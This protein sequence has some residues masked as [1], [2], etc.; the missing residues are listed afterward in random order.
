MAF[1]FTDTDSVI[2]VSRPGDWEP[3][4]GTMLGEW[5]S[6]LKDNEWI[7]KFVSDGPKVYSYETNLGKKKVKCKGFT[8]NEYTENILDWDVI[9]KKMVQTGRKL[10]FELL[11][12]LLVNP[13][14]FQKITYPEHIKRDGRTQN[15]FSISSTKTLKKVYDKRILLEDYTTMPY[16][17]RKETLIG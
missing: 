10:D 11:E 8:Q 5:T 12:E 1:Y 13:E 6:E 17:T 4:R 3:K 7:I 16:G 15:I 2:F 14:F 9:Q